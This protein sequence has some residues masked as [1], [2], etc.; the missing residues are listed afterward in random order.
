MTDRYKV[1]IDGKTYHASS[2]PDA[3]QNSYNTWLAKKPDSEIILQRI[4]TLA[5]SPAIIA[6]RKAIEDIFEQS[7]KDSETWL[8]PEE[9][10]PDWQDGSAAIEILYGEGETRRGAVVE[11]DVL[12][13][14]LGSFMW[15]PDPL[16]GAHSKSEY[17]RLEKMRENREK[18][19]DDQ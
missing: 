3:A 4:T 18:S 9:V 13:A 19:T 17:R 16:K 14:D 12:T 7:R 6:K 2:D 1:T 11:W 15:R 8:D 10:K 5:E